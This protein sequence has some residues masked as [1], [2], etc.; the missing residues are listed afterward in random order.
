MSDNNLP[1]VTANTVQE[2]CEQICDTENGGTTVVK[3]NPPHP[4]WTGLYGNEVT[5]GNAVVLGGPFGL[6]S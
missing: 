2:F 3:V 1:P 5:Q 6:N 4:V